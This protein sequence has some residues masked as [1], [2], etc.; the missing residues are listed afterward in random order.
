MK[1]KYVVAGGWIAT[2][3]VEIRTRRILGESRVGVQYNP[4]LPPLRV[5]DTLM[6]YVTITRQPFVGPSHSYT[7]RNLAHLSLRQSVSRE[8]RHS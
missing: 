3:F 6:G 1:R 5:H 8:F 4:A 7:H 2:T